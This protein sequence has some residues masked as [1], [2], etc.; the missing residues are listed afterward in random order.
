MSPISIICHLSALIFILVTGPSSAAEPGRKEPVELYVGSTRV[1]DSSLRGRGITPA[2]VSG[3][4][5]LILAADSAIIVRDEP[6]LAHHPYYELRSTLDALNGVQVWSGDLT[7]FDGTVSYIGPVV[8]IDSSGLRLGALSEI[9]ALVRSQIFGVSRSAASAMRLA[10]SC[11]ATLVGSARSL[12]AELAVSV[13]ERLR[14]TPGLEPITSNSGCDSLKH[15]ATAPEATL[16]LQSRVSDGVKV[17]ASLAVFGVVLSLPTYIGTLDDYRVEHAEYVHVLTRVVAALLLETTSLDLH[18][19]AGR[20][21]PST[22]GIARQYADDRKCELALLLLKTEEEDVAA[23]LIRARC[24]YEFDSPRLTE[25]YINL[26]LRKESNNSQAIQLLATLRFAQHS[27]KEAESLYLK[28]PEAP[29]AQEKLAFIKFIDNDLTGARSIVEKSRKAG[30]GTTDLVALESRIDIREGKYQ[31]AINKLS[32]LSDFTPSVVT[33]LKDASIAASADVKT[34]AA[35][36]QGFGTL[37]SK[38]PDAETYMF[39]G[40]LNIAKAVSRG[41]AADDLSAARAAAQFGTAEALAEPQL[42]DVP[43]LTLVGLEAAEAELVAHN[44]IG[45]RVVADKFINEDIPKATTKFPEF[46][47]STYILVAQFIKGAAEYISSNDSN[48]LEQLQKTPLLYY[49]KLRIIER[50]TDQPEDV[51]VTRSRWSFDTMDKFF[52]TQRD[53]TKRSLLL[54]TSLNIQSRLAASDR[55]NLVGRGTRTAVEIC[56]HTEP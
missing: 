35:A 32:E 10:I 19:L 13:S 55:S 17:S 24:Y 31:D 48:L 42:S 18:S 47:A 33:V 25:R 43:E 9:A 44:Y 4:I 37:I 23:N 54:E 1:L 11:D 50:S 36:E 21:G 16:L 8:V 28:I 53:P 46:D 5:K 30:T 15:K 39:S 41:F 52:C 51:G 29:G 14:K 7:R 38:S 27:F 6:G 49:P 26:V 3:T 45:A 40:R 34:Y 2:A 22:I 20:H 56:Q 12:I